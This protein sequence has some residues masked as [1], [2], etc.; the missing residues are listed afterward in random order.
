VEGADEEYYLK[1][2]TGGQET[3]PVG[4]GQTQGYEAQVAGQGSESDWMQGS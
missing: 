2:E 3:V 1:E 4:A